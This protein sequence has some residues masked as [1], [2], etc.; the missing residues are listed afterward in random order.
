M[1]K[2]TSALFQD[3]LPLEQKAGDEMDR[4]INARGAHKDGMEEV[5]EVVLPAR[6]YTHALR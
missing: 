5:Q 1:H 6:T 3:M 2:T 4:K